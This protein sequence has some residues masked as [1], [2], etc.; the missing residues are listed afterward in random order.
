MHF[1]FDDDGDLVEVEGNFQIVDG[2]EINTTWV[3]G[4]NQTIEE[5]L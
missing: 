4:D 1:I 3:G 2:R 5:G